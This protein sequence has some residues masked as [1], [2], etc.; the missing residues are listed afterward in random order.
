ML[1]LKAFSAWQTALAAVLMAMA[2]CQQIKTSSAPDITISG[3]L[4]GADNTLIRLSELDVK[5]VKPI[6]SL[7]IGKDG[8][9]NFE[10]N[11]GGSSIY[12]LTMPP[13]Q[14]LILV[15]DP[16]D[17]I[18]IEGDANNMESTARIKGSQASAL[19]LDFERF[20]SYNQAKADS[21]ARIFMNSLSDP[22]FAGIKQHLD[23]VYEA[24]V[25]RQKLYMQKFIDQHTASLA[26]LIVLNHKFGPNFIFTEE[27]D[28]RYFIKLDSGLMANFAE[29][30]HALDHHGR[31]AAMIKK[32][33]QRQATDSLLMPGNP[34]PD[35]QLNNA[36]GVPVSLSALKGKV[37][38]VYFWAAMDGKSR[39]FIR[40]LIPIYKANRNKGFAIYGVALEPNKALW[41]NALKLDQPGGIQSNVVGG[42]ESPVAALFGVAS[43]P[44]AMLIDRHGK[45][46]ARRITLDNL[47]RK[48]PVQLQLK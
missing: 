21:L 18:R 29:N 45:I 10:F 40:Q 20:T 2:A 38:L 41:L 43:L 30:K 31:V 28:A 36:Q 15:A 3:E 16:G 23:S 19:L 9:F 37:V 46:I 44:E 7:R 42:T 1:R 24:I 25:D 5:A 12:L 48:L 13:A 17:N 11:Q 22:G 8:K 6:D 4:K 14:K 34:A 26:S 33:V 27:N 39:K 47:R 32:Q 35:V